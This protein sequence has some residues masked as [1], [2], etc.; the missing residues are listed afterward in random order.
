MINGDIEKFFDNWWR[1]EAAL[2]YMGHI[3]WCEAWFEGKNNTYTFFVN[4]WRTENE[5]NIEFHSYAEKNGLIK[6]ERI[7]EIKDTD[8]K[9]IK[10]NFLMTSIFKGKSFWQV[11]RVVAWLDEGPNII[12]DLKILIPGRLRHVI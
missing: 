10:K 9:L 11:E 2:F 1:S 5:D 8:L 4:K 12:I 7:F 3:Y 6:Y